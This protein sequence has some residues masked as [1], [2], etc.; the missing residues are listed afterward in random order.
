MNNQENKDYTYIV[1]IGTSTGGPK[2]LSTVIGGLPKNTNATY[3]VVQHMP[4]GFT[5]SLAE[6]LNT[7]SEVDVKEAEN[8]DVLK[9]GTVYIAPGGKQLKIVNSARPEIL[10]T[11]E[12][13]YKSHKPSVNVMISSIAALKSNKN[14]IGVIMTG[15]GTDG[16]EGFSE[17]KQNLKCSIVAQDEASCVVYGMPKAVVNAGLADYIVPAQEITKTIVKLMGE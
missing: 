5:K 8:G 1:A 14:I 15:M 6:R 4:V 16:L 2:A 10:L 7:I 11:D 17:L 9:K 13:P 3:V 12:P